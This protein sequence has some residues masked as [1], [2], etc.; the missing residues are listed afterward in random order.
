M[1]PLRDEDLLYER[2]LREECGVKTKFD[3]YPGLPH[4]FWAYFPGAEF[5]LKHAEDSKNGLAWLVDQVVG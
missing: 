2:I 4:G 1:D 3:L 5:T